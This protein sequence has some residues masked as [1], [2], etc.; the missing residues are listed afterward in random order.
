MGVITTCSRS[1]TPETQDKLP[2]GQE[3]GTKRS[4]AKLGSSDPAASPS[5]LRRAFVAAAE[6]P[7]RSGGSPKRGLVDPMGAFATE[8]RGQGG[9]LH[10][11]GN[12]LLEG[13]GK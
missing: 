1:G 5:S 3:G 7:A 6:A 4:F 8:Q 13:T 11:E 2:E 9:E 12:Q 10:I